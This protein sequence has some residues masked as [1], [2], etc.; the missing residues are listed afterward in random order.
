MNRTHSSHLSNAHLELS[1][2][3]LYRIIVAV[4][5]AE[6]VLLVAHALGY[7]Q[8]MP[9]SAKAQCH[10]SQI[11]R[12]ISKSNDLYKKLSCFCDLSMKRGN[13]YST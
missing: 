9:S 3:F 12:N 1:I 11:K 8:E 10:A 4:V 6:R 2:L 13:F 5:N 7:R